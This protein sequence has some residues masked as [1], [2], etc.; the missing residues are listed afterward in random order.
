MPADRDGC[1]E[2]SVESLLDRLPLQLLVD[3]DDI[4][5]VRR[6][7]K[8]K[9]AD[10]KGL[11]LAGGLRE[12][13]FRGRLMAADAVSARHS[14]FEPGIRAPLIAVHGFA[15]RLQHAAKSIE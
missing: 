5:P 15:H 3:C 1:T 7:R 2:H 9:V 4:S 8:G 10:A 12:E 13:R 14:D 6:E 11:Y